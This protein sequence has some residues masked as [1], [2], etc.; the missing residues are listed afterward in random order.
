MDGTLGPGIIGPGIIGTGSLPG[1]LRGDYARARP[2]GTL[3]ESGI[4]RSEADH[5][6]W[7]TLVA[8]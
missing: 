6:T 4:L 5:A 8:R 7:R 1:G 2:D 3:P